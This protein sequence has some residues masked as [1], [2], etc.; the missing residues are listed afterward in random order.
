MIAFDAFGKLGH[1]LGAAGA[2]QLTVV[3]HGNAAGIVAPVF[4]ATQAFNEDGGN[5]ARRDGSDDATHDLS[6]NDSDIVPISSGNYL[7]QL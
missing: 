4:K 2:A 3:V 6:P 5:V 7:S 1:A